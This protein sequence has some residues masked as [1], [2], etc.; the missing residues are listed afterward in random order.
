MRGIGYEALLRTHGIAQAF[1]QFV[2]TRHQYAG[3]P[4]QA[5]LGNG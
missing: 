5:A 2:D 4:W 1:Q 3:L